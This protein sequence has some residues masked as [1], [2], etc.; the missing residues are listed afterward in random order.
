M[1]LSHKLI[2]VSAAALMSVSPLLGT[3]QNVNAATSKSSKTTAKKTSTKKAASSKKAT[4]KKTSSKKTAAKKSTSSKKSTSK[5]AS[6]KSSSNK[7][8]LVHNAYVYDKKGKRL[9]KYMGSAKYTTIAKGVTVTSNG[10]V[11][12][13]GTVYYNLGGGAY[14]KAVNVD[15]KAAATTNDKKAASSKKDTDTNDDTD[16]VKLIHN[17]YVYDK[18]G[19]RIKKYNGKSKL[20]KDTKIDVYGTQIINDKKYYQL[21]EK[22]TAFVK[23]GNIDAKKVNKTTLKHNA[24]IYDENG[25]TKKKTVKKGKTVT[26]IE[27]RYIG[28]KL[29]YKI[30]DDQ[31]IKASNAGKVSGPE[32]EPVN[33]P[34]GAATVVVP[35]EDTTDA[36]ASYVTM[37]KLAPLYNVKGQADNTRSFG[38]GQRQ[39]VSELRYIATS[40]TSTPELFYKLANG[41]GYVKQSD[42]QFSGRILNAAN[43]PEQAKADVT[44]ATSANKTKLA[45]SIS[46]ADSVRNSE[47]FKLAS[48]AAKNG[49]N[50]AISKAIKVNDNK[51]AT[52]AEV[53]D[54][55]ANIVTAKTNLGGK[56]VAVANL[57]NLTPNEVTEIVKLAAAVNNVPETAIQFTNNNT[58]LSIVTNGYHQTL[59][60]ND[61]AVQTSQN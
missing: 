9:D 47:A 26:I 16:S 38:E 53:N 39:Q 18:N 21:D 5:K 11:K 15:G 2:M 8:T 31:F 7:I 35:D 14:I 58:V 33:E 54:A 55:E 42:V 10:T 12:I 24:Y 48:Q 23:A 30:G 1:K 6:S 51:T 29:Y 36:N 49:Y 17:A 50:E 61:Y 59:N 45:Q 13:K 22:G 56:K 40:A 32:L 3:N 27:A 41:R 28:T 46:E 43:T 19:K 37:T 20:K 34:D 44:I 57:S 52:I 25:D 60:I 4:A